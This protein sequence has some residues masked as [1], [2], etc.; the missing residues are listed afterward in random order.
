VTAKRREAV[1]AMGSLPSPKS[2]LSGK[3]NREPE[4]KYL[5][6]R[7]PSDFQTSAKGN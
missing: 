1:V 6:H 2:S 4:D 5:N 7:I 3:K